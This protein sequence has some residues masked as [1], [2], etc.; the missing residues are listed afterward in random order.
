MSRPI[1]INE[2][3]YRDGTSPR[4]AFQGWPY[5]VRR[6]NILEIPWATGDNTK[7]GHVRA[8]AD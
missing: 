2:T 1:C 5:D 8:R 6:E 4:E 3:N 7:F